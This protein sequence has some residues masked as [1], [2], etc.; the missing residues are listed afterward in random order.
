MYSRLKPMPLT[1][2]KG[3]IHVVNKYP[4]FLEPGQLSVKLEDLMP[5]YLESNLGYNIIFQHNTVVSKDFD[6]LLVG[7]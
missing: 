3:L 2:N 5:N 6:T 4:T 7:E 1:T